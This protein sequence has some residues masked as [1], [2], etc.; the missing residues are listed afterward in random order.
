MRRLLVFLFVAIAS[1]PGWLALGQQR[2]P[3]TLKRG[4]RSSATPQPSPGGATSEQQQVGDGDVV[5]IDANL[6]TVPASVKDRNGKC[7]MD[8]RKKDFQIF[9]DGVKQEVAFFAQ[10]EQ[11]FTIL[12]LLDMSSSMIPHRENL[13]R[14]ANAFV[15]QLRPDDQLIA[16]SFDDWVHVLFDVTKVSEL[17]KGFKLRPGEYTFLYDAVDY[18]LKRM[19]KIKGRKAIVLFS[20]GMDSRNLV[21]G[22]KNLYDAEEQEALVYTVQFNPSAL[23]DLVKVRNKK[24][25]LED[26]EAGKNYMRDLAEKTGGQYYPVEDPSDFEKTFCLIADELG[27]QYSLG[28]YPNGRLEAGQRREIKVKLDRPDLVVR[29]RDSYIVDKDRLRGK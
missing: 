28:Y 8:L 7:V 11:P 6:V 27:R 10:V 24:K 17:E 29:A 18:A 13:T 26:I 3:P 12:F 20:D 23:F 1:I 4:E 25:F 2:M 9:E 15:K 19:R 5:R 16:V 22:K 14:A 21:S